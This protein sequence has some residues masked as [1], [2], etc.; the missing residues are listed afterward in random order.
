MRWGEC[1]LAPGA[2]THGL[3]RHGRV[4]AKRPLSTQTCTIHLGAGGGMSRRGIGTGQQTVP[5]GMGADRS[6]SSS[7][8]HNS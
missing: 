4:P 7:S 1:C 8:G 6:S 5:G 2:V 3:A